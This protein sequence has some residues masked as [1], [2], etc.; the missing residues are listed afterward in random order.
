MGHPCRDLV[1]SK[2][3]CNHTSRKVAVRVGTAVQVPGD[4]RGG[5]PVKVDLEVGPGIALSSCRRFL[6]SCWDQICFDFLPSVGLPLPFL[7]YTYDWSALNDKDT[8]LEAG[9]GC[10]M[11]NAGSGHGTS[12]AKQNEPTSL[13]AN[14]KLLTMW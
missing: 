8:S 9:L 11:D 2:D 3:S 7:G 13:N 5:T 4:L 12:A 14:V 1:D 6:L 10:G